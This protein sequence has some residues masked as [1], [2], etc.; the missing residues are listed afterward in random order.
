MK[1]TIPKGSYHEHCRNKSSAKSGQRSH[2]IGIGM[3]MGK[4]GMGR[5][6][7]AKMEHFDNFEKYL[8]F[9][10]QKDQLVR[11]RFHSQTERP[12]R[13]NTASRPH[14]QQLRRPVDLT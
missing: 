3:G 6:E 5:G 7:A 11:D 2:R 12:Y 8:M 1:I 14:T 13:A 10:Q 4:D 9:L